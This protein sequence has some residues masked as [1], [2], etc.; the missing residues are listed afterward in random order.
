MLIALVLERENDD[1]TLDLQVSKCTR[2]SVLSPYV[3]MVSVINGISQLSGQWVYFT[4]T[5]STCL[6]SY[7]DK[8]AQC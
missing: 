2:S 8:E 6:I 3:V 4:P 7:L 5:Q 1:L